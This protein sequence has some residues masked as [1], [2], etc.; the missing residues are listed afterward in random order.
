MGLPQGAE[1]SNSTEFSV[2]CTVLMHDRSI[3]LFKAPYVT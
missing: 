2:K 1:K 3:L